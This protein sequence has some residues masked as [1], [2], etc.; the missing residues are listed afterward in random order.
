MNEKEMLMKQLRAN[1]FP[2]N[3]GICTMTPCRLRSGSATR[4]GRHTACAMHRRGARMNLP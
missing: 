2:H 1:A 4:S 3:N